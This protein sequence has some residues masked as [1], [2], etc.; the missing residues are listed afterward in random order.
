MMKHGEKEEEVK[1][2][3]GVKVESLRKQFSIVSDSQENILSTG[4]T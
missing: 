1:S 4:F 3:R 2:C